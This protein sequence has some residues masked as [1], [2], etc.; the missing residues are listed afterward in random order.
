MLAI[1]RRYQLIHPSVDQAS[2]QGMSM[3]LVKSFRHVHQ[4]LILL[5][6]FVHG[7]YDT[8]HFVVYRTYFKKAFNF[9]EELQRSINRI[10]IF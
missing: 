2:H 9:T 7:C 10:V 3:Q 8:N 6:E 4:A 1:Q 5:Q